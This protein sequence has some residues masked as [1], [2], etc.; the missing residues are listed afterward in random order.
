[1][2]D[3]YLAKILVPAGSEVRVGAPILV[4]V[5]NQAD[6][7]AFASFTA[8]EEEEAAT[9]AAPSSSPAPSAPEPAVVSTP[10]PVTP[11]PVTTPPAP[12]PTVAVAST[13]SPTPAPSPAAPPPSPSALAWGSLVKSSSP[14]AA[15]IARDQRAYVEKF[16]S[17][18]H[19]PLDC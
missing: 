13:P 17:S 1:V 2:D 19:I 18:N 11:A 12:T 10:A 3:A 6:V 9:P 5:E 8:E 4:L 15:K 16:G 14:L 7:A